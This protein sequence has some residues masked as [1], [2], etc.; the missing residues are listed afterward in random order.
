MSWGFGQ[1]SIAWHYIG[2]GTPSPE[3]IA[4]VR[5]YVYDHP[6]EDLHQMA[7]KLRDCWDRTGHDELQ[8]LIVYNSGSPQPE[9][10]WYWQKYLGNIR[11]YQAALVA[12]QEMLTPS[13]LS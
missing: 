8:S 11:N 13:S 5:Q 2:D 6:E 9:G 10:N 1:R 4:H 12:A 7:W 3:N